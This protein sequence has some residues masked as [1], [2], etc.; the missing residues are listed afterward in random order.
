MLWDS[1]IKESEETDEKKTQPLVYINRSKSTDKSQKIG[2]ATA[3]L[4]LT[5]CKQPVYLPLMR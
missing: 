1:A 5:A 4:P 3:Y 2:Q